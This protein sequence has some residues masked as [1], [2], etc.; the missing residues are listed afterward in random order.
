MENNSTDDNLI[1]AYLSGDET[2]LK[3]LIEKNLKSVYNF[4]YQYLGNKDDTDDATQETFVKI[5]KNIKRY[6]AG[7]SFRAWLFRI[8]KNT[9][10]DHIKKKKPV[11]FSLLKEEDSDNNIVDN[12]ADAS[13][14][15]DEILRRSD[16]AK[17]LNDAVSKLPAP[18][19][20]VLFL[21]YQDGLNFRQIA[22]TLEESTDTVKSRHRRALKMLRKALEEHL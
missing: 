22:E 13:P 8:A 7:K 19:R 12:I 9:A 5:W 6:K 21:Y 4:I 20:V 3:I 10:L 2:S 16:A 17:I 11:S 1:R 18:Y 15:P 14:F